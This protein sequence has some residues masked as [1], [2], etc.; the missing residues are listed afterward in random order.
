MWGV[1]GDE[2]KWDW[3]DWRWVAAGDGGWGW[4]A[5]AGVLVVYEERRGGR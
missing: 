5:R 3:G 4:R 1:R 2:M